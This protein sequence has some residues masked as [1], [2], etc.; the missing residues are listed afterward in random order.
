[1]GREEDLRP[2][3]FS[4]FW[5]YLTRNQSRLKTPTLAKAT[6][7]SSES[8]LFSALEVPGWDCG[9]IITL[10]NFQQRLGGPINYCLQNLLPFLDERV[11]RGEQLLMLL[12]PPLPHPNTLPLIVPWCLTNLLDAHVVRPKSHYLMIQTEL[13]KSCNFLYKT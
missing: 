6:R 10:S 8:D 13:I 9:D 3:L 5:L 12:V 11:V 2:L 4:R 1:M 7:D